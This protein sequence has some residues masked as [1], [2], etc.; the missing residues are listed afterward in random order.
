MRYKHIV[1]IKNSILKN[2]KYMVR[3]VG[4]IDHK[5]I[6][7]CILK[8][9]MEKGFYSFFLVYFIKLLYDMVEG[10]G[11]FHKISLFLAVTCFFQMIVNIVSN[12]YEYYEEVH[13]PSIIS[14]LYSNVFVKAMKMPLEK[15][16]NPDYYS[17]Y[18]RALNNAQNSIMRTISLLGDTSGQLVRLILLV[19]ITILID[20]VLLLLPFFSIVNSVIV[21]AIRS[22]MEFRQRIELT[23]FERKT[24]YCKRV[25]Y[26]KKYAQELRLYDV[27]K[28]IGNLFEESVS[29]MQ[30]VRKKYM[31]KLSLIEI[32]EKLII[33][34]LLLVVA[35]IYLS[36]Q[37]VCLKKLTVGEFAGAMAAISNISYC[38]GYLSYY[39]GELFRHS[40]E[41]F[42]FISF[43]ESEEKDSKK[44]KQWV[45]VS[46][47][48]TLEANNL[49]YCY[50]GEKEPILDNISFSIKKGE[51]IALAG[52]NGAGKTTL[53]KIILGLYQNYEGEIKWN[54]IPIS[55][56]LPE[57]YHKKISSVLQ[58]FAIY[59]LPVAQNIMQKDGDYDE[60]R[61]I[62][63][64][65]L[66]GL[67]EKIKTLPHGIQT[68]VFTELD[69][70]GANFSGG[71]L[72]KMALSRVFYNREADLIILD[73]PTSAMDPI[74]EYNVYNNLFRVF[75]D[76]T[77]LFVSH[78]LLTCTMADRIFMMEHGKI[79]EQGNHDEL[80]QLNGKYAE[81]YQVQSSKIAMI[82]NYI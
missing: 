68:T 58:D 66:S 37:V 67:W 49:S 60:S 44:D 69:Q 73:E 18:T 74:S 11:D 77:I 24:S 27:K 45:K 72:Q 13:L 63:S 46:T 20:P 42:H 71:E 14:N 26:E 39:I 29:N 82:Q 9:V 10:N 52:F 32:W 22:R 79:I 6:P 15:V 57:D 36:Y 80:M 48:Q 62:D 51:K 25:F 4:G 2:I 64:L 78:R 21:S 7:F 33:R 30:A 65:V 75:H 28:D 70:E 81:M 55:E 31:I 12:Q 41:C 8:N 53:A 40:K 23:E 47:L 5:I 34:T 35:C 50:H 59:E 54:Q 19:F 1:K 3:L 16:E 43:M 17:K 56:F 76:K 61:L 38:M